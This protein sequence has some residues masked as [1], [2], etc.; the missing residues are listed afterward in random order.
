[1]GTSNVN[2]HNRSLTWNL[3]V[4]NIINDYYHPRHPGLD[5]GPKVLFLFVLSGLV[6]LTIEKKNLGP[7]LVGRGD[8]KG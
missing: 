7:R 1:M 5:P 8:G 2:L 4:G 6:L 3:E